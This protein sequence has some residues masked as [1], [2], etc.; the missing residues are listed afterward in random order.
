MDVHPAVSEVDMP[1]PISRLNFYLHIVISWFVSVVATNIVD[2][3][4]HLKRTGFHADIALTCEALA[5]IILILPIA[6]VLRRAVSAQAIVILIL[7]AIICCAFP[8]F[9]AWASLS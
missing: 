8:I 3:R 7:D 5:S 1:E 2:D 4:M 6:A 9:V